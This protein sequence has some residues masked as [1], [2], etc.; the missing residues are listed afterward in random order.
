MGMTDQEFQRY[1]RHMILDDVGEEGQERL[2][3]SSALIVGMGGL[4]SPVA[5]YLAAAGVGRLGL[6][7]DD[8]VD[9]TNLQRQIAHTTD[10]VGHPKVDS[11]AASL[12][13]INPGV[14]LDLHRM[15]LD[16]AGA[17][18]LV[19][20]YDIVVD[21][22]DNFDTRYALNDACLAAGKTLVSGA[23]LQFD[24]QV[25]TL[26]P[27]RLLDNGKRAPC[28]RCLF[29]DAPPPD[30]IPRC[31]QAG[32]F[33]AVAGVIG[34]L[35]AVEVL[36]ELLGLKDSLAGRLLLYEGRA[37]NFMTVKVGWNASCPACGEAAGER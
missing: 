17:A 21:G 30:T 29:P 14:R 35:Q 10:R 8:H 23:L 26:R 34:T 12:Q 37:T 18:A 4:G 1:A 2:L 20:D 5:L 15:R 31:T 27:G 11:A 7:D 24:G 3:A 33:G 25:T 9:L 13:A 6:V 28:Y 32:I 16:A 36:K 19:A 22:S